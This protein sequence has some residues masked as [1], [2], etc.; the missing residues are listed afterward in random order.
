M[1]GSEETILKSNCV[2][3]AIASAIFLSTEP[4]TELSPF[5]VVIAF[6]VAVTLFEIEVSS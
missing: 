3:P 1:L 4:E 2:T 6:S 5:R